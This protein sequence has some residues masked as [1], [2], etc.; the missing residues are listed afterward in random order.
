M[1]DENPPMYKPELIGADKIIPH[2]FSTYGP[3]IDAIPNNLKGGSGG[4][5]PGNILSNYRVDFKKF[6]PI[7]LYGIEGVQYV[8]IVRECLQ[9]LAI[10]HL[11]IPC[12]EGSKNRA[13]LERR[14]KTPFQV[15]FIIDPNTGVEMFESVE[16]VKYLKE[17]YTV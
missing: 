5:A 15:P 7:E 12:A 16:I 10:A 8:K 13:L 14:T 3:G 17:V 6:K 4:N 2:L 9:S 11:F 1:I